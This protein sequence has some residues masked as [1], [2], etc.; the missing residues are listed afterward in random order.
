MVR[1]VIEDGDRRVILDRDEVIIEQGGESVAVKSSPAEHVQPDTHTESHGDAEPTET[2]PASEARPV[3]ETRPAGEHASSHRG[4][5]AL[6]AVLMLLGIVGVVIVAV[7]VAR[8]ALLALEAD[9]TNQA[10]E[11]VYD[12]TAPM[13]EPFEGVFDVQQIDGAGI[14]EP[15]AAIAGGIVLG[16]T[17][18]LLTAGRLITTR[19]EPVHS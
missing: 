2:R 4:A 6:S 12:L 19:R 10:V 11:A 8:M 1:K 15:A 7:L 9:A 18:V 5:S 13:I 16:V 3:S 17:I 14:F